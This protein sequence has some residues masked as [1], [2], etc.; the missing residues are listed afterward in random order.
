MK[1]L[2][3]GQDYFVLSTFIF[4]GSKVEMLAVGKEY[5]TAK[6]INQIENI[7]G[8]LYS[9]EG[10]NVTVLKCNP[11]TTDTLWYDDQKEEDFV[12]CMAVGTW[13]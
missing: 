2:I 1:Q 7:R 10:Y 3:E 12:L 5:I 13:A 11:F 8:E 4:G 9:F 6:Y